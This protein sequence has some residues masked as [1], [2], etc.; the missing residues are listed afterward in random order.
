MF[1]RKVSLILKTS[2]TVVKYRRVVCVLAL[3]WQDSHV[4]KKYLLTTTSLILFLF[5]PIQAQE[6]GAPPQD[7]VVAPERSNTTAESTYLTQ[8]ALKGFN[9]DAQGLLIQSLDG[10]T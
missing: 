5:W 4:L 3:F 8:L 10:S 6:I 7:R 9:L 1:L 2:Q